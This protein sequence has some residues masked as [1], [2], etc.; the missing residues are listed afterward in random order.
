[1]QRL[2]HAFGP[3]GIQGQATTVQA[4]IGRAMLRA[5]MQ[6]VGNAGLHRIAILVIRS[7]GASFGSRALELMRC[8]VRRIHEECSGK[9]TCRHGE[10]VDAVRS[11]RSGSGACGFRVVLKKQSQ[12]Q[13]SL[14]LCFGP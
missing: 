4:Q 3:G 10:L 13:R 14:W 1:M 11:N 7:T 9:T 8:A 12:W 2:S 6:R 5:A